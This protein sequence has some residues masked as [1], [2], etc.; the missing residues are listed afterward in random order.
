MRH[1]SEKMGEKG[2]LVGIKLLSAEYARPTIRSIQYH[3]DAYYLLFSLN[4]SAVLG[5]GEIFELVP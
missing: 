1:S 3:S 4:S 2:F 5:R